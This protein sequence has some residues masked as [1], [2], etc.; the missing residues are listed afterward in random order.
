MPTKKRPEREATEV[1][2]TETKILKYFQYV[3]IEQRNFTKVNIYVTLTGN[4]A[5]PRHLGKQPALM[6]PLLIRKPVC[7]RTDDRVVYTYVI[8]GTCL[9]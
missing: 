4:K 7:S 2:I 8:Q 1:P 6:G 5:T 9:G 3:S